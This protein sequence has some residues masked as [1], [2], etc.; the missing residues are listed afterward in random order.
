VRV[1]S[2]LAFADGRAATVHSACAGRS[3][4]DPSGAGVAGTGGP[5]NPD[6]AGPGQAGLGPRRRG[7]ACGGGGRRSRGRW[8]RRCWIA[9]SGPDA[10][11]L[12]PVGQFDRAC[13]DVAR[14]RRRISATTATPISQAYSIMS[15]DFAKLK[16]CFEAGEAEGDLRADDGPVPQ[17][18]GDVAAG[19]GCGG[20]RRID[21]Q[22]SEAFAKL[23]QYA[24]ERSGREGEYRTG[25]GRDTVGKYLFTLR[26]VLARRN[27]CRRARA[28]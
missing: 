27:R 26:L 8:R 17:G 4:G 11:L 6:P 23:A 24:G 2:D 7:G 1:L 9:G 25:S 15:S 19:W 20:V 3:G 22:G 28:R 12:G 13:A 14:Q 16:H 5:P 21:R 18:A 10:P